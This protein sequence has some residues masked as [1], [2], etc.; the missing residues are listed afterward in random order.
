MF[1]QKIDV[2]FKNACHAC[3][4]TTNVNIDQRGH[5]KADIPMYIWIEFTNHKLAVCFKQM[6]DFPTITE[7]DA[8]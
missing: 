7:I 3:I 5:L 6:N 1:F 4:Y 8:F 2:H